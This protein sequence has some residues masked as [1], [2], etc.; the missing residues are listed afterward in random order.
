LFA[1]IE[2]IQTELLVSLSGIS[3]DWH[4]FASAIIAEFPKILTEFSDKNFILLW[5]GSRDG[6]GHDQFQF[7]C[8]CHPNTLTLI[9]DMD[10]NIFWWFTQV[11]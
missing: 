1:T 11:E 2:S 7:Y 4:T 5:Q 6:F 9:Q 3:M 10:S 8:D